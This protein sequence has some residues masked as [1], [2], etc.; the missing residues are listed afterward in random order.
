MRPRMIMTLAFVFLLASS[1]IAISPS[2]ADAFPTGAP[3]VYFPVSPCRILDTRVSIGTIPAT[4]AIDVFVRGSNL[5]ASD[6]AG[7]ADCNVPTNAEVAVVNITVVNPSNVGYIRANAT[8]FVLSPSGTYSR[9]SYR[10]G[11]NDSNEIAVGLCNTLLFPAPHQPCGGVNGRYND[12]QVKNMGPGA[13]DLVA[14]VMGY[15]A[16]LVTE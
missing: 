13:L 9:M 5:L 16:R 10:P 15:Y 14:D 4:H 2:R 7:R 6:G 1:F 8:G 3:L 12:F 11:Q